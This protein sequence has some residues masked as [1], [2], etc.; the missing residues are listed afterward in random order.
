MPFL[1]Y[2]GLISWT[3]RLAS[4]SHRQ[5]SCS[6]HLDFLYTI[7]SPWA[8]LSAHTSDFGLCSY[9]NVSQFLIINLCPSFLP[10][11]PPSS[12]LICLSFSREPWLTHQAPII[13]D[14]PGYMVICGTVEPEAAAYHAVLCQSAPKAEPL[15]PQCFALYNFLL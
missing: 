10:P 4:W 8:A 1:L 5:F 13:S 3:E 15:I 9:N 12:F 14:P 11:S 7:S 2:L 6:P